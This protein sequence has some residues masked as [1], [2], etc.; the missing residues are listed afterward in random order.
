MSKKI[1]ALLIVDMQNDFM[2]WGHLPTKDADQII[3]RINELIP[4]FSLVIATKDWHPKE[5]VS[6]AA[7]HKGKKPGDIIKLEGLDQIL[8]P[9]HCVQNTLGAEFAAELHQDKIAKVFYKGIDPLIDSYSTFFDNAHKRDT[10]LADYLRQLGIQEITIVGV[11]TDYCVLYSV[12]DAL[13]LGF[14]VTVV[15]DA[16]KGINIHPKDEERA[17]DKMLKRGAKILTMQN[18]L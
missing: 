14:K 6:F 18:I 15:L 10:G 7:N 8:W 5:H 11:A 3:P 4:L 16:C 12:L 9:I 2:S 13:Q 1:P 17:L